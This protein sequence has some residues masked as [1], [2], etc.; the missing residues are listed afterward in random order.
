MLGACVMTS[1]Y[2]LRQSRL[3]CVNSIAIFRL[4]LLYISNCQAEPMIAFQSS[5]KVHLEA[6]GQKEAHYEQSRPTRGQ[7]QLDRAG[8]TV[9]GIVGVKAE[10]VIARLTDS[11]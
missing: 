7:I 6:R 4:R 8:I 9:G 2:R 11:D 1:M 5:Y 10:R 3:T